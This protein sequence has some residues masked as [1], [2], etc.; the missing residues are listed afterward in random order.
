M[1]RYIDL[2]CGI[3]GFHQ[4]WHNLGGTCVL[5]CEID[6]NARQTYIKNYAAW[7]PSL[8][9]LSLSSQIFP[10]DITTLDASVINDFDVLCAGFPCQPFSQA[11][12]K[13]GFS[14]KGRG[15]LFFEIMRIVDVKRPKVLF[16]EN[17]RHLVKHDKGKTF[18]R[19]QKEIEKR[20]YSFA[21]KVIKAS[22]FGLPQLRP[23]VY[24][25]CFDKSSVLNWENFAFPQPIPLS[26]TM[27]DVFGGVVPRDI[28]FTLRVGGRSSPISD[29]RNWDGYIVD[30][31]EK[32]LTPKEGLKMMGFPS[33]FIFPVSNVAAMKQLGNSVA[34][35]VIEAI[36]KQIILTLEENK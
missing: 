26:L 24:I 17:V 5:S 18:T 14:D 29:R 34:V 27:S 25:V 31:K 9:E 30:G 21:W 16:L 15:N 3:G 11:G 4:A 19:I 13:N 20:G 8:N 10:N 12:K 2:F 7:M 6:G 32:R 1:L 33:S 22:E 23:R 28:G 36:G 35:P